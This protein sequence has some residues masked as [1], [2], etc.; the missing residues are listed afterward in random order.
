LRRAAGQLRVDPRVRKNLALVVGL[1]GRSSEAE[2]IARSELPSDE[3][4]THVA[5]LRQVLAL[6]NGWKQS[7]DAGKPLVRAEGS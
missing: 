7:G 5:Y 2:G 1:Q 4:T 3:A 6:Q